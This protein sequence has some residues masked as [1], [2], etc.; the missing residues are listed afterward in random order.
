MKQ[1]K[2]HKIERRLNQKKGC[3][4]VVESVQREARTWCTCGT[5]SIYKQASHRTLAVYSTQKTAV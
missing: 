4:A 2:Q 1:D 5:I 3:T